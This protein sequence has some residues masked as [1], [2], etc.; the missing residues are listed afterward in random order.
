[1][2]LRDLVIMVVG[3]S[4]VVINCRGLKTPGL[5]MG[6]VELNSLVIKKSI[7]IIFSW[8]TLCQMLC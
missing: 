5:H 4:S 2:I 7:L 3:T 1:M 8:I 6:L